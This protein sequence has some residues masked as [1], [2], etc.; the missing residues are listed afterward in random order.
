[1][2]MKLI[3]VFYLLLSLPLFGQQDLTLFQFS[4][5]SQSNLVNPAMMP[6]DKIVVGLPVLSSVNGVYNNRSFA[7][8]DGFL[9]ENGTLVID[10]EILVNKLSETNFFNFQ[11]QDQW[12]LLG[13][14][15]ND[16]YFQKDIFQI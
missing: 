14:R 1:M 5:I 9:T 13:Y 8:N 10:P 15:K 7:L 6:E 2:R 12:F 16:N 4:G 3:I 11:A